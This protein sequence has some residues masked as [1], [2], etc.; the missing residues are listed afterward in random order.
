ME[1]EETMRKQV[2]FALDVK[3]ND[4]SFT[5]LLGAQKHYKKKKDRNEDSAIAKQWI[6]RS[7]ESL[8]STARDHNALRTKLAEFEL[9]GKKMED[10]IAKE[11]QS[12]LVFAIILRESS[13]HLR[14]ICNYVPIEFL[15]KCVREDNY[16]VIR[17][18][19]LR[20]SALEKQDSF[21]SHKEKEQ[22]E[23]IKLLFSV[24]LNELEDYANSDFFRD[25]YTTKV[26][27]C[28]RQTIVECKQS[29]SKAKI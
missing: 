18:L 17:A 5:P 26:K 8:E 3:K 19:L 22:I 20:N 25:N 27:A 23:K 9:I 16:Y 15:S 24:S 11:G 7:V 14:F 6:K 2:K 12:L 10:F 13:E 28:F 29:Y 21:G 1:T 4:N